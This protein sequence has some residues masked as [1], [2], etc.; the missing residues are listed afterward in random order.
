MSTYSRCKPMSRTT[1]KVP[2][3]A[4]TGAQGAVFSTQ[5]CTIEDLVLASQLSSQQLAG[6]SATRWTGWTRIRT[7]AHWNALRGQNRETYTIFEGTSEIQRLV[8]A[9]SIS[10]LQIP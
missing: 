5:R 1:S 4:G 7:S 10:G 3:N 8:I 6:R 2:R 9:R